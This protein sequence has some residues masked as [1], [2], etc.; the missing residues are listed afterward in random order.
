[1]TRAAL[2][3]TIRS[4]GGIAIA[5]EEGLGRL[6]PSELQ[7]HLDDIHA[8]QKLLEEQVLPNLQS[9]AL[10]IASSIALVDSK[11]SNRQI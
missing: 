2:A 11:V 6:S 5:T 3:L 4:L 1:M 8:A 10:S 9:Y 7:A